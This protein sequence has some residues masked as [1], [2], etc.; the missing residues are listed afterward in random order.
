MTLELYAMRWR[1]WEKR[2]PVALC[3]RSPRMGISCRPDILG[4]TQNRYLLEIEIKRTFADFMANAKKPHVQNRPFFLDRWPKNF[5]FLVPHDLVAKVEPHLPKWAGLLC[6]PKS[7]QVQQLI[8]VR[9]APS[10]NDSLRL[11]TREMVSLAHC[12]ANQCLAK[13]E[14]IVEL[15]RKLREAKISPQNHPFPDLET[16]PQTTVS[17]ALPATS[18]HPPS[19]SG[20]NASSIHLTPLPAN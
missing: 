4:I 16:I 3:E 1:R 10:N 20:S 14:K 9:K 2:C 19:A 13:E 7:T 15:Q 11:T 18:S 6:A 12:M 8:S 17:S 5:W